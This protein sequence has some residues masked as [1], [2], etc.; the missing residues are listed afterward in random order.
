M[1]SLINKYTISN[2][3]RFHF[4]FL[5]LLFPACLL[6][7]ILSQ[8]CL[9]LIDVLHSFRASEETNELK[10]N[11]TKSKQTGRNQNKQNEIKTSPRKW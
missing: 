9:S 10:R 1:I 3:F 7:F 6:V 8:S 4:L 5:F 11:R 2:V